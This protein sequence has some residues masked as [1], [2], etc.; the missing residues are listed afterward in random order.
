M[1]PWP[2]AFTTWCGKMLKILAAEPV[3]VAGLPAGKPG[4]IVSYKGS[5]IILVKEGGILLKQVQLA[6]KRPIEASDFVNGQP[7]FVGAQLPD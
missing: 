1:T 4:Q 7:D 6:G 3:Y 5:A 2:S